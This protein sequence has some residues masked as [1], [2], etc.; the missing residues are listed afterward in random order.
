MNEQIT[1]TNTTSLKIMKRPKVNNNNNNN[2]N[3][4]SSSS[5]STSKRINNDVDLIK[6]LNLTSRLASKKTECIPILIVFLFRKISSTNDVIN[7]LNRMEHVF[8][9]ILLHSSISSNNG[10]LNELNGLFRLRRFLETPF[11]IRTCFKQLIS[12]FFVPTISLKLDFGTVIGYNA[13]A[14]TNYENNNVIIDHDQPLTARNILWND[15]KFLEE[16]CLK[17]G[18]SFSQQQQDEDN[19]LHLKTVKLVSNSSISPEVIEC[20][21]FVVAPH[22]LSE[23]YNFIERNNNRISMI[24]ETLKRQDRSFILQ[25][26]SFK[27]NINN[28]HHSHKNNKSKK[29]SSRKNNH[30]GG[31]NKN[32]VIIGNENNNNL[33]SNTSLDKYYFILSP[34]M[35]DDHLCYLY[36]IVDAETIVPL[37]H[38]SRGR[39]YDT[40]DTIA[41]EE[42][43]NYF[44]SLTNI[45][46]FNPFEHFR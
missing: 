42:C 38:N 3:N 24:F 26:T 22:S 44:L 7:T 35:N 17:S 25:Y 11:S 16:Q 6:A 18:I 39:S 14:K 19:M 13:I 31:C 32:T 5:T 40:N 12:D 41:K 21:P 10:S 43:E 45:G 29:K 20:Y 46:Q 27:K 23:N 1:K 15:L 9:N 37:K 4:N 36:P 2:N 8:S 33:N 30:T 34:A 28:S